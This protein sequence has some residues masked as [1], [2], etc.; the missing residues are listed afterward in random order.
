MP[1][2]SVITTQ[3]FH[4]ISV[5]RRAELFQGTHIGELRSEA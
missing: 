2:N 3:C 4:A 5:F 1:A